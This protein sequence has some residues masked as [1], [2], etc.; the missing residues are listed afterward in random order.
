MGLCVFV[1]GPLSETKLYFKD[2]FLVMFGCPKN[3]RLSLRGFTILRSKKMTSGLSPFLN[4]E[5]LGRRFVKLFHSNQFCEVMS[6]KVDDSKFS[7][8]LLDGRLKGRLFCML[9]SVLDRL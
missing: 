9:D 4:V 2:P 6:T 5:Q 3:I 8:R 7:N 1:N